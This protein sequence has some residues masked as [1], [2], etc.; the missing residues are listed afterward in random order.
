MGKIT[1]GK[2]PDPASWDDFYP[3]LRT[4]G[5]SG[6][7]APRSNMNGLGNESF[8]WG[9]LDV[10]DSETSDGKKTQHVIDRLG[11]GFDKPFFLACGWKLP[12]LTWHA[13]RKYFDMYELDALTMPL[14][15]EDDLDD[16]PPLALEYTENSYYDSVAKAGKEREGVQAYLACISFIDAQVGRVLEALDSSV[17]AENTIVVFW[18]DHGWHLGEKRHWSKS[19]SVFGPAPK[20]NYYRSSASY[21]VNAVDMSLI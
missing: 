13:P 7:G 9:P 8:D 4:Q 20:N 2:F 17:Y 10:A 3:D 19:D 16:L 11:K 12:H 21:I 14:I 18:G 1:H 5:L 15:A 6:A